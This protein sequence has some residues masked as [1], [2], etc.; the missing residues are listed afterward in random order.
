MWKCLYYTATFLAALIVIA[1]CGFETYLHWGVITSGKAATMTPHW[2][3]G[4][5]AKGHPC[6]CGCDQTGQCTCPNCNAGCGF[7]PAPAQ[8]KK[9]D[10]CCKDCGNPNCTCDGKCNCS[11]DKKCGDKCKCPTEMKKG[12]AK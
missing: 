2:H 10:V 11:K 4:H 12:P 5:K 7:T 9:S 3:H 1:W 6:T 8:A